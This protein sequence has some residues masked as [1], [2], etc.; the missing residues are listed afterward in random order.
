MHLTSGVES[1]IFCG[2]HL[3]LQ[4]LC[5]TRWTLEAE[6]TWVTGHISREMF[7]AGN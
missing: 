2:L 1:S 3:R 5:D 4:D 7:R 6:L